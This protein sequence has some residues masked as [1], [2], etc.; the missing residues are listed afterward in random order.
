VRVIYIARSRVVSFDRLADTLF[1]CPIHYHD[2]INQSTGANHGAAAEDM[3][4]VLF[5]RRAQVAGRQYYCLVVACMT[6]PTARRRRR[7]ACNRKRVTA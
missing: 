1:I 3:H 4:T 6:R 7:R 2:R 5:Y